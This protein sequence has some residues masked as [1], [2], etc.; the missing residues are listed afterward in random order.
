VVNELETGEYLFE[1]TV[2]D[3]LGASS[4]DS[5][6][7]RVDNNFHYIE[8]LTVYPNPNPTSTL[9][10]RCISDS[11]GVT[12]MTI[13]DM[14]GRRVKTY[15]GV[16]SQSFMELPI[17]ISPLKKGVYWLEI[18]IENKKRMITKFIKR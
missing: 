16:K 7:V 15:Q 2:T 17:N 3:N 10:V 12:R 14:N 5:V 8:K 11:L 6:L 4:K 1:L 13:Y 18:T 9:T